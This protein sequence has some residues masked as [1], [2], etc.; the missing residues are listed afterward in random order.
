[1]I[2]ALIPVL[3]PIVASIVKSVFPSP[4]DE[5]KRAEIQAKLT[6]S[7]AENASAI[8]RAA[9]EIIRTEAASQHWLAANWRPLTALIFVGLVVARWFGYTAPNM[10]EAEYVAVYGI[11]ELMIGGYVVSRGA[12]KVLPGLMK[13]MKK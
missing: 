13:A 8:E 2:A 10:T 9:A 11:I 4:E 5:A 3:G 7:L 1:M 6:L 12:E